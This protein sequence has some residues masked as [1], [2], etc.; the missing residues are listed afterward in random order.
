MR[1]RVCERKS[2]WWQVAAAGAFASG[3]AGAPV[4]AQEVPNPPPAGAADVNRGPGEPAPAGAG[5]M[6]DKAGGK[7]DSMM[8]SFGTT[9]NRAGAA[10]AGAALDAGRSG[11]AGATM[12]EDA[13]IVAKLHH[14][15]QMEIDTGKQAQDRGQ[16]KAVRD[17]GARLVRDHQ[18]ADKKLLALADKQGLDANAMPAA[19]TDDEAKD[20]DRMERLRNLTGAEFDREF[21]AAM[22]EGHGKAIDLVTTAKDVV[23][24]ARLRA[25]LAGLLPT[26][27]K[28][29]QI[30]TGLVSSTQGVSGAGTGE[31]AAQ[32]RRGART[33]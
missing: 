14:I 7:A 16:A 26:L 8:D 33:R 31:G 29:R 11:A 4:Q 17:F 1:G 9:A 15:N 2:W 32:G 28:H 21:A 25:M 12:S 24:D 27:E 3:L 23:S 20:H 10:T 22:A 18:A 30:A 5:T 6:N 19:G 13:R